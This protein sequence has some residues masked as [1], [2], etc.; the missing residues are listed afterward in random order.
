[1]MGIIYIIIS[2]I[3]FVSAILVKKTD[4]KQNILFWIPLTAVIFLAF[5]LFCGF[6]LLVLRLKLTL[7]SLSIIN[8]ILSAIIIWRI[9]KDKQIQKYYIK[10]KDIVFLALLLVI[11][12]TI[13]YKQYGLPFSVKYQ[14][15]DPA[16]HFSAAKEIYDN[17][18]LQWNCSMPGASL[19]TAILFNTMDFVV[20]ESNF[21]CLFI[22]FDL[23]ILYL[24]SVMFYIGIVKKENSIIKSIIAFIF[25]VLFICGY[26]LNSVLFGFAYLTV[27]ILM[28]TS[29]IAFA[30]YIID[31]EINKMFKYIYMF[32]L[33]FGIFFS[34][35]FFVPVIYATVGL[36]ILFDMIKNR[37]TKNILSIFTK[38]NIFKVIILLVIPIILGISYFVLP[39]LLQSNDVDAS[40]ISSE[41]FMYRD[42]YSNFVFIIPFVL[43]FCFDKIK[44]KKNCFL[45]I[46][47][48]IT[49]VF[50]L[51]LFYLGLKGKVSSY[52]YFKTY[53]LISILTMMM[54]VKALYKLIDKKEEILAYSFI[55]V[56]IAI[57]GAS[58][59]GFDTKLQQKNVLFNPN[60]TLGSYTNLYTF[61]YSILQGDGKI[62]SSEQIKAIKYLKE[63]END[64]N[65]I[66]VYGN[67]LQ[68]MWT[69]NIGKVTETNDM[70]LLQTPV[71]LNVE[72]WLEN[73][74][75][76]YY[77]C[78]NSNDEIDKNSSKYNVFYEDTGVIV[79]SKK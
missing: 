12:C 71:E 23:S 51:A 25:A 43:Y 41:G 56:Y 6:I 31:S 66:E 58:L 17:K 52:Y 75:K 70:L 22:I 69:S 33:L 30:P 9:C 65:K 73:N 46:L 20:S 53:F 11:I 48:I 63:K 8:L 57:I 36:Y 54:T 4:K 26:P 28:M 2:L 67:I 21:Y 37:K 7:I 47:F 18:S 78:F 13:G 38:E 14:T 45:N 61:N 79:L 16:V 60:G 39:A 77:I 44:N 19:N 24:I 34:Y 35:Y 50:T 49:A 1:M 32:L 62:L 72:K 42:L 76:Q 29:I 59:L 68:R 55:F 15:T 3:L 27:G 5:N 64:K 10:I 74:V 40:H